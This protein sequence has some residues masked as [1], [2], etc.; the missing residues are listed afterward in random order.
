MS[1][2]ERLCLFLGLLHYDD[3]ILTKGHTAH[4]ITGF[5]T[6]ITTYPSFLQKDIR[7]QE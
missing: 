2:I 6:D 3:A 5:D 4:S 7:D 1:L